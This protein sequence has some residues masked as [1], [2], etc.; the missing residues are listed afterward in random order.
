MVKR[1]LNNLRTEIAN[2][3]GSIPPKKSLYDL[4]E[5]LVSRCD[6]KKQETENDYYKKKT[7][8]DNRCRDLKKNSS[9]KSVPFTNQTQ[10]YLLETSTFK[11][12]PTSHFFVKFV[13]NFIA[14]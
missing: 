3:A 11:F 7:V 13:F 14:K 8:G 5:R 1:R 6:K 2:N 12:P 4:R 10:F 9:R